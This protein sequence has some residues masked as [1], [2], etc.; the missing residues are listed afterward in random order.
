M[1][2]FRRARDLLV[3]ALCA[4]CLLIAFASLF[5]PVIMAVDTGPP[6]ALTSHPADLSPAT[7]APIEVTGEAFAPPE[8]FATPFQ[9]VRYESAS[10]GVGR[11]IAL[12]LLLDYNARP[13]AVRF[14]L[15]C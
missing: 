15:L 1:T 3:L 5:A 11:R 7:L 10:S 14:P 13:S 8:F 9:P 2:N 6:I 12:V 4:L